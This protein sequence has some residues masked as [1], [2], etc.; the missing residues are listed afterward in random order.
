[1]EQMPDLLQRANERVAVT[2]PVRPSVVASV[3]AALLT[4]VMGVLVC[5]GI[6]SVVWLNGDTGTFLDAVRSGGLAWLMAHGS[7][8]VAGDTGITMVPLGSVALMVAVLARMTRGA[9][10]GHVVRDWV[11][12]ARLVA[13]VSVTYVLI[14]VGVVVAVDPL[15]AAPSMWRAC[16][17]TGSVAVLGS[18]V[19]AVRGSELI[20]DVLYD[21]PPR[22]ALWLAAVVRGAAVSCLTLLTAGALLFSVALALNLGTA[23]TV[24]ERLDAGAVGG[25]A[26]TLVALALVPNAAVAAGAYLA[27][28]GFAVGT[29]TAVSPLGV[30]LGAVPGFPLLAALPGDGTPA[31]WQNL[32]LVVPILAGVVAGVVLA[33]REPLVG[34]AGS[35]GRPAAAG[36]AGGLAFG[37]LCLLSSG[38]VG[39]GR[40]SDVGP[41]TAPTTLVVCASMVVGAVVGATVTYVWLGR[42]ARPRPVAPGDGPAGDEASDGPAGERDA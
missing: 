36:L 3:A 14:A 40:M 4:A 8:V 17:A 22:T 16:L 33:R 13:G 37:L 25:L 27:G 19:G 12:A 30:D 7:G 41:A 38:A 1:M 42:R 15:G 21:L 11:D 26:V 2:K 5:A 31:G 32:L 18:V 10:G 35:L 29:D 6:T 39:P 24:T 9:R 34:W 23:I 20:R 28:P